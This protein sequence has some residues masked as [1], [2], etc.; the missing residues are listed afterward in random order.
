MSQ[1]IPLVRVGS[2]PRTHTPRIGTPRMSRAGTPRIGTPLGSAGYTRVQDHDRRNSPDEERLPDILSF[3]SV[4]DAELPTGPRWKVNLYMLMERP[5]TSHAAFLLH[6]ITTSLIVISA[7]VT[8]L[9]TIPSFHSINPSV[10][11]G[12]ETS[13]VALFTVEYIARCIAHSMSWKR[14]FRWF[15]CECSDHITSEGNH[16]SICRSMVRHH[17]PAGYLALLH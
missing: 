6:V 17:R 1:S 13:L 11:F 2:P 9:E 4:H 7:V 8:V 3:D 5:T 14:F 10:W 16:R 12:V 15:G